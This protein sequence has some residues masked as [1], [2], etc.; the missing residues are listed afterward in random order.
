MLRNNGITLQ[1]RGATYSGIEPKLQ[2]EGGQHAL[3]YD[4]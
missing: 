1:E 3:E 4:Q 2:S